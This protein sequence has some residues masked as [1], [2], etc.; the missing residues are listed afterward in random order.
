MAAIPHPQISHVPPENTY[1][2]S[3]IEAY[4]K[5]SQDDLKK[6]AAYRAEEL[7]QSGM[8][9]ILTDIIYIHTSTKTEH[10]ALSLNIPLSNLDSHSVVDLT[11]DGAKE[12]DPHPNLVKDRG[13]SLL[14]EKLTEGDSSKFVVIVDESKLVNHIGWSG[15]A[16]PVEVVS[17]CWKFTAQKLQEAFDYAG[18]D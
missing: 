9:G 8:V 4:Q 13:G 10:Q 17:I 6:I 16:L 2:A 18:C 7:V 3:I 5:L 11:I 1:V 15:L 14:R 12:V